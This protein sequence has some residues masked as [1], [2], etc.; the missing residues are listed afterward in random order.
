LLLIPGWIDHQQQLD[1]D[2]TMIGESGA[3]AK[4]IEMG[5]EQD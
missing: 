3:K 4:R 5:L 2:A 1:E